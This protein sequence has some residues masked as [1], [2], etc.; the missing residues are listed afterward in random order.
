M[1]APTA[2]YIRV[3]PLFALSRI[4]SGARVMAGQGTHPLLSSRTEND[5]MERLVTLHLV[6]ALAENVL[7]RVEAILD[8]DGRDAFPVLRRHFVHMAARAADERIRSDVDDMPFLHDY[9]LMVTEAD[10]HA[11]VLLRFREG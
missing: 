2:R 8:P 6:H 3:S 4:R 9:T 11:D 7:E 5:R 10:N 1:S